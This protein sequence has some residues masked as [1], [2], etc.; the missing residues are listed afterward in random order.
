MSKIIQSILDSDMY[1]LTAELGGRISGEHGIGHK[2]KK[3]MP[4]VMSE[5]SLEMIRCVKRAMDPQNVLNPGKIVD[6]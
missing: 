4:L 6:A 3:Y 5:A 2:R 1:K